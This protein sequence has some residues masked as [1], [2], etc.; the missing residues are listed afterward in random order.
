LS[1]V[2]LIARREIAAY[3]NT[4]TGYIITIAYLVITSSL[5]HAMVAGSQPK[6][7]NQMLYDFFYFPGGVIIAAAIFL[8]MRLIAEEKQL[9]TAVLLFT[10]PISARQI[11]YGKFLSSLI[12]LM[13]LLLMSAYMPA[14]IYVYGKISLGHLAAGYLCLLLLGAC[15]LAVTL[16][17]STA[18]SHQL[19]AAI[20]GAVLI[21]VFL[22][23]WM[24]ADK[25][26]PPF[27]N[28][29]AYLAIH[30]DHF[31][32]MANGIIHTRS[33]VYYFSFIWLF[34]E[35]SVRVLDARRWRG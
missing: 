26:D 7:S 14:L 12:I 18:T 11:I 2:S 27:K 8:G 21:A 3:F 31:N 6:F 22:M 15:T 32:G 30:N 9:G 19:V 25:V 5:F 1:A 17:M 29:F 33:L 13:I 4:W 10:S 28:I 35:F 23:I 20:L 34:L 24:L 16:F